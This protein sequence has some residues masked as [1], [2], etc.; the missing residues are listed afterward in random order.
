M[1]ELQPLGKKQDIDK[2]RIYEFLSVLSETILYHRAK[3][4]A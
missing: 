1:D 3:N 2:V 4:K